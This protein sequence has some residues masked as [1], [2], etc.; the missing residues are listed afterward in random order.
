M[1]ALYR[2]NAQQKAARQGLLAA[3]A[4]TGVIMGLAGAGTMAIG[5]AAAALG[6]SAALFEASTNSVLFSV[7]ASA[8]R[9]VVQEFLVQVPCDS[10]ETRRRTGPTR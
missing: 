10:G 3:T 2:F 4:T 9:N 1:Y 5:I 6:L 8:V 7:E